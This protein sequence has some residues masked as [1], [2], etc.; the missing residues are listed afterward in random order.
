MGTYHS[1]SVFFIGPHK[2][3]GDVR[4]IMRAIYDYNC[5]YQYYLLIASRKFTLRD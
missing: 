1:V 4:V 5:I 3:R 2:E